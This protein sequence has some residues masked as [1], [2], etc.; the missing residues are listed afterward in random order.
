ME[1]CSWVFITILVLKHPSF[2]YYKIVSLS[3]AVL[4]VQM[5]QQLAST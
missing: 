2:N 1:R 3:A 5:L 4:R